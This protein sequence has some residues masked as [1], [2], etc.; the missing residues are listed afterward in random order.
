[1]LL[2]FL[3]LP[4]LFFVFLIIITRQSK[5]LGKLLQ[6]SIQFSNISYLEFL[7]LFVFLSIFVLVGFYS[8]PYKDGELGPNID[9]AYTIYIKV[10]PKIVVLAFTFVLNWKYK[11][12]VKVAI[13]DKTIYVIFGIF[14]FLFMNVT[15]Y[16]LKEFIGYSLVAG[17]AMDK[18]VTL[19]YLLSILPI[20][21]VT[22][23]MFVNGRF[24][25]LFF[26]NLFD[27]GEKGA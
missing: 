26:K 19:F 15:F 13:N 27:K 22:Y 4:L 3:L 8:F 6:D 9:S 21:M 23:F 14:L 16:L 1:M 25:V 5:V 12:Y 20:M 24:L 18:D 17:V 11:S 10:L 7:I 2:P